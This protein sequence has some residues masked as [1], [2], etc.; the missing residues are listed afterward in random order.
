M[1]ARLTLRRQV[2]LAGPSGAVHRCAKRV[3]QRMLCSRQQLQVVFVASEVAPWSKTGG[4]AD[5]MSALPAALVAR[6]HRVM[7]VSPRYSN[8]H[9][10]VD[11]G[12]EAPH[13]LVDHPLFHADPDQLVDPGATPSGA[14]LDPPGGL[15]LGAQ[16]RFNV[17]CQAALAAPLHV[18][19]SLAR[20]RIAFVLHNVAHSGLF[21][22]ASFPGLGL[23][24][25]RL[26]QLL[27]CVPASGSIDPKQAGSGQISWLQAGVLAS[28]LVLTVSPHH[29]RELQQLA[30]AAE[31]GVVGIM[32]GVDTGIWCPAG[33]P[34][35]PRALH[36][37]PHTMKQGKAAAKA[38]LQS[39]LGLAPN[40]HLPLF[41]FVGR[42]VE[43]KGADLLLAALP[44][45][46]GPAAP[47][48]LVMVGAGLESQ[49]ACLAQLQTGWAG[50]A[51]GL[52]GF[53]PPLVHL[54]LAAADFLV[55]P[56]R[57]EPCG[58]LALQALRYAALPLVS[59]V[60]GLMDAVGAGPACG[61]EQDWGQWQQQQDLAPDQQLVA[62]ACG[63]SLPSAPGPSSSP[64]STRHAVHS[65]AACMQRLAGLHGLP[66]LDAMRVRCMQ[67]ELSWGPAATD[68][69]DS[70]AALVGATGCCPKV[71]AQSE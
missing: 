29:A 28:D 39:R 63:F 7:T 41:A 66:A 51:V 11:T 38:L 20:A 44:L 1:N 32:N 5:V 17:L 27:T 19:R 40:P 49:E 56:S 26:Q 9:N 54:L 57:W 45:L 18:A 30:V 23:P 24:T 60:G 61:Q 25:A 70:L 3:C 42:L 46:L 71:A 35:L 58:L 2:N 59:P 64:S 14:Y 65:L 15:G 48:T 53:N 13:V 36:Y 21:S 4:L 22:A 62:H 52:P 6:G 67:R 33:D 31:N 68:W 69:E 37:G 10:A 12:L 34:L 47:G 8:Y 50:A 16:A 55:L 43:Q